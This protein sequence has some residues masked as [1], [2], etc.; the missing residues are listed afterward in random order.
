MSESR[1]LEGELS[2]VH[3]R[4][5]KALDEAV[6]IRSDRSPEAA[7]RWVE[8]IQSA[9]VELKKANAIVGLCSVQQQAENLELVARTLA[10]LQ[11]AAEGHRESLDLG[12]FAIVLSFEEFK[13]RWGAPTQPEEPLR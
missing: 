7:R 6:A 4:L 3:S 12:H 10:V 9:G 11:A 13:R 2:E 8:K 1:D 5:R